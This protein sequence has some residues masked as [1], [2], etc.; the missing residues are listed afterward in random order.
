[1]DII[2]DIDATLFEALKERVIYP[3][4]FVHID[5]PSGPVRAHTGKGMVEFAGELWA[6]VGNLGRISIPD[7][8][9]GIVPQG[10]TLELAAEIG[11]LL[12]HVDEADARGRQVDMYLGVTNSPG[13]KSLRGVPERFFT[14]SVGKSDFD[15]SADRRTAVLTVQVKSGQPARSA[16]QIAHSDEDQQRSHPGDTLF[17][18]ISHAE[19][20]RTNPPQW[21]AP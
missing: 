6:G 20:W 12:D 5:W 15:L 11:G 10:A 14:G 16:A 13:G 21:P 2:R 3:I 19:K 8:S 7:E 1:M 4:V 18:R 9:D 17:R